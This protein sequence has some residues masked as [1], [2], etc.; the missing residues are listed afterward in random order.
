MRTLPPVRWVPLLGAEKKTTTTD[1]LVRA[2]R[3]RDLAVR[4]QAVE[5][6]ALVAS[7]TKDKGTQREVAAVLG[8]ALRDPDP[9]LRLQAVE[10][11]G[12]LPAAMGNKYLSTALRDRNPFVRARVI[13]VIEARERQAHAPAAPASQA[14][15]LPA[16]P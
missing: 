8:T 16:V 12:E 6:L 13:A 5:L 7:Q 3:D 4:S 15:A 9:G 14:A 2:L 1:V 11:L 10:R